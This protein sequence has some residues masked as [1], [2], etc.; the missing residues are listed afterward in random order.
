MQLFHVNYVDNVVGFARWSDSDQADSLTLVNFSDKDFENYEIIVPKTGTWQL[1]FNSCANIY[2]PDFLDPAPAPT[3]N[4]TVG[5][6]GKVS[7]PLRRYQALIF[8]RIS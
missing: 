5:S 1:V 6:D 4:I 2:S 3:N 7:L 8:T